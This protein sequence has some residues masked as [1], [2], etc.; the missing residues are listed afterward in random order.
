MKR[1]AAVLILAALALG[2]AA[3]GPRTEGTDP[4]SGDPGERGELRIEVQNFNFS[5]A[6]LYALVRDSERRLLGQ[7]T[8]KG[9]ET[10]TMRWTFPQPL[11]LEIDLLA[12][13]KCVTREIMA[14]PGDVLD[15]QIEEH[16]LQTRRCERRG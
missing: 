12:G 13:P 8:G 11:R 3:G 7:V 14:D 1:G 16:F 10:F 2:C 6:R 5:D 4:F 15:L 9:E